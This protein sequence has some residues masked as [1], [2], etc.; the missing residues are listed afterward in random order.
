MRGQTYI[1]PAVGMYWGWRL[2]DENNGMFRL[3]DRWGY[4]GAEFNVLA[5]DMDKM[6]GTGP[7]GAP[8]YVSSAHP[9]IR[10]GILEQGVSRVYDHRH[11]PLSSETSS[12]NWDHELK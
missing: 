8:P 3:G 9:D 12:F 2:K 4:H 7:W 1:Q 5:K 10:N 11:R 6:S